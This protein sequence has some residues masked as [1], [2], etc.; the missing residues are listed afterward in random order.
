MNPNSVYCTSQPQQLLKSKETW[1]T[2]LIEIMIW[3]RSDFMIRGKEYKTS[4]NSCKTYLQEHV[5]LAALQSLAAMDLDDPWVHVLVLAF[6]GPMDLMI[7]FIRPRYFKSM[8]QRTIVRGPTTVSHKEHTCLWSVQFSV[9][10]TK[11]HWCIWFFLNCRAVF[12]T[13]CA[14]STNGIYTVPNT[15]LHCRRG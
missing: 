11:F 1:M 12:Y 5:T 8:K 3:M 13:E 10:R 9:W 7:K 15:L 6:S 2:N 14:I 4:T